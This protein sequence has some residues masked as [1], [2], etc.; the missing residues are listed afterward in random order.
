MTITVQVQL[1]AA[2][3]VAHG[4]Y[5]YMPQGTNTWKWVE[6]A[7][8]KGDTRPGTYVAGDGQSKLTSE[9]AQLLET[10]YAS[11]GSDDKVR[12]IPTLIAN[13]TLIN[14]RVVARTI[15]ATGHVSALTE[16]SL[17]A[18]ELIVEELWRGFI[19]VLR[20]ESKLFNNEDLGY[21]ETACA[22]LAQ[23]GR[24]DAIKQLRAKAAIAIGRSS[25]PQRFTPPQ[26][27]TPRSPTRNINPAA[28]DATLQTTLT[29]VAAEALSVIGRIRYLRLAKALHEKQNPALDVDRQIL[30]SRL[31]MLGLSAALVRASDEI[32]RRAASASDETDAKG[33]MDLIRAFLEEVVEESVRKIETK[34]GK[35]APSG[36]RVSHYA[37]FRQYLENAGV[38]GPEE[39]E[40][41]QKLYN[42]L[43]NQG[44]HKLTSAPEQLHVA[45]V[46][47]IEWCMLVTGRV[48]QMIAS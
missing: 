9:P 15:A 26:L 39:S 47:V 46:T 16:L 29:I 42:F 4:L 34:V 3:A 25:P 21:S 8:F 43:S 1:L 23:R 2:Q 13:L 14:A 27:V 38:I 19:H 20:F 18:P 17:Q 10:L 22:G 37:P 5:Q 12:F 33:V 11:S 7:A 41:M 48:Q 36:T 35:P 28:A 40:L 24:A 30:V 6:P 45:H 32:E 44:A 31:Q